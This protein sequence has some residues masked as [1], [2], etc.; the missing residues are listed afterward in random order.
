MGRKKKHHTERREQSTFNRVR[1]FAWREI[2]LMKKIWL[3]I[4]AILSSTAAFY[5]AVSAGWYFDL[6]W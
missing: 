2:I 1:R 5:I 6:Y 3:I 4:F